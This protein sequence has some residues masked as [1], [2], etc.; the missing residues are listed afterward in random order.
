MEKMKEVAEK[1][2]KEER[3][4][5]EEEVHLYQYLLSC[6]MSDKCLLGDNMLSDFGCCN[7]C[8]CTGGMCS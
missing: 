3:A 2:A 7:I 8:S 5:L 6:R 1:K 4:R